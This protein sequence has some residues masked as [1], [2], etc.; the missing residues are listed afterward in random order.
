MTHTLYEISGTKPKVIHSKKSPKRHSILLS[1][2]KD[3]LNMKLPFASFL[4]S[5]TF[6]F[7]SG[8]YE[9]KRRHNYSRMDANHFK[10][11]NSPFNT[12]IHTVS[13]SERSTSID[14]TFRIL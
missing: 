4:N 13:P 8:R 3:K 9:K 5:E 14:P 11:S 7:P 6:A 2:S 1:P 12:R 10:I